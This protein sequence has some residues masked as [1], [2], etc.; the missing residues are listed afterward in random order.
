MKVFAC[1][2]LFAAV[3]CA[4]PSI[5]DLGKRLHDRLT[6]PAVGVNPFIIDG[7][8]AVEKSAPYVVSLSASNLVAAHSCAGTIIGKEWILTAAHC[9]D[10]LNKLTGNVLGLTVYAGLT[11][12]TNDEDA[13][14][15]SIDFAFNHKQYTG[16]EGSDDIALLHVTPAFKFGANVK[17]AALPYRKEQFDG[18]TSANYGWGLEDA[19]S[20]M[21]V[22]DLKVAKS[23]VL[24][25][26]ECKEALP[27]DAPVSSKQICV[28]V[29]ACYGDGGSPLVVERE[30]DVAE[31][32]GIT[33]WGYMPCGYNNRPTV[34]TAVSQYVDWINEVQWA[35]YILY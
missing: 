5:G 25:A 20:S 21:Y 29:A 8:N 12:R 3:A 11:N 10:E 4:T 1:L 6:G 27:T 28:K 35:Y 31:L 30:G 19:E 13:Q 2:V 15:R 16:V 34:Y 18:E 32:I 23:D 26:E 9:V 33:S 14:V 24:T 22:K 17:A 7:E